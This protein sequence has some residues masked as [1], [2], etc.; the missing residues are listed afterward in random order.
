MEMHLLFGT[1]GRDSRGHQERI[2]LLLFEGYIT[3]NIK[4]HLVSLN[5]QIVTITC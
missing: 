3:E 5:V 4:Q 2:P 1:E